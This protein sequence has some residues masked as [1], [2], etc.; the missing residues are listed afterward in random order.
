MPRRLKT[1]CLLKY[2]QPIV[3]GLMSAIGEIREKM[4]LSVNIGTTRNGK[5]RNFEQSI[6]SA[7]FANVV[8]PSK[9][10]RLI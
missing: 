2:Q 6:D 7:T 5:L 10:P 3:S 8:R 1:G 4:I 9:L